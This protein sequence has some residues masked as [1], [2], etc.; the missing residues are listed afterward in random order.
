MLN[1]YPQRATDPNNLHVQCDEN[2]IA[3]N[4]QIIADMMTSYPNSDVLLA[5][6]NLIEKRAYLKKCLDDII[7]ELVDSFGKHLKIIRLTKKNNPI[8]PLYQR[9]NSILYGFTF[10]NGYFFGNAFPRF[11]MSSVRRRLPLRAREVGNEKIRSCPERESET[12]S[13]NKKSALFVE[14]Q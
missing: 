8:H 14:F 7:A 11:E 6:S 13:R 12:R 5:Y 2:L 4:K 1:I 9:D 3:R 10:N